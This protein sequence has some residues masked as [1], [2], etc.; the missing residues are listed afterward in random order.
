MEVVREVY[1]LV[2][3]LPREELYGVRSQMT[4]A[5]VSV[6]CNIAEGWT[7]EA[8]RDKA[9]FLAIAHGSAAELETLLTLCEQVGWFPERESRSMRNAIDEVSRM[10]TALRRRR[11]ESPEKTARSGRKAQA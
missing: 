1:R 11:R 9:H 5:A 8:T 7:R 6:A 4:R 2:P 3:R 10:L